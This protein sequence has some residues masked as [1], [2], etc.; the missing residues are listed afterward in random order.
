MTQLVKDEFKKW[1]GATASSFLG[2]DVPDELADLYINGSNRVLYDFFDSRGIY[3]SIIYNI[4]DNLWGF[5]VD[6][7]EALGTG[8]AVK[9]RLD[10]EK[11]G[12]S[13]CAVILNEI[14]CQKQ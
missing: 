6:S 10:A 9:N 1:L 14:L 7:I 13:E 2:D 11:T 12:F 3:L 8:G 5:T 4:E